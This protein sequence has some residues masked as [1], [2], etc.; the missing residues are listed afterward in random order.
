MSLAETSSENAGASRARTGAGDL[1]RMHASKIDRIASQLRRRTSGKP[2]VLQ[3]KSVSHQVPKAHDPSYRDEAIDVSDLTAILEIDVPNRRCVAEAGVTFAELVKATLPH[4]LIPAVVPELKTI[5]V[6]GAVAGCSVESMSFRVGGFHDTCLEYEVVTAAGD[7]LRCRPDGEHALLFQMMHG[8]FGT[9]GI[10]SELTF[11]LV[12]ARRHVRVSY[13]KHPDV[14]AFQREIVDHFRANDVD[15]MDGLIHSPSEWV[16]NRASF[17]DDAPYTNRYDWTKVYYQTTRTRSEDFLRTEDYLFR[18]DRGVTNVHPRSF[19]GRLLLGKV[20][21]SSQLLRLAEIFNDWLP[22]RKPTVTL[23]VFIPFSRAAAFLDWFEGRFRFF[24]LWCVP[25]RRVRDYEWLCPTFYAGCTDELFLDL[26][27]YGMK[28]P[29]DHN[30]YRDIE[31]ALPRFGG[32]K[33][34]ISH[35]YYSK[36][37]FWGIWNKDNHDKVKALTDPHNIFLDLYE[38]TC[39]SGARA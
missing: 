15:F 5:T 1:H 38:K 7:V 20:L 6:G 27:I 29:R 18:Y 13:R 4:G 17:V 31:E 28:Q 16:L 8:T 34:L 2:L 37:A 23:D 26:A 9:M 30:A 39:R 14:T 11:R 25:Y 21:G 10:L 19:I 32:M 22:A 3:K 36:D 24:P 12:P 33:T 35:N